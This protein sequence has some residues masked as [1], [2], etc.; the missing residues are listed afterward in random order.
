MPGQYA[1]CGRV[2]PDGPHW[3]PRIFTCSVRRILLWEDI[4]ITAKWVVS[5]YGAVYL[6]FFN[7]TSLIS[8]VALVLLA[9]V[10]ANVAY[11]NAYAA[12]CSFKQQAYEHPNQYGHAARGTRPGPSS[13]WRASVVCVVDPGGA[14]TAAAWSRSTRTGHWHR[15]RWS[16]MSSTGSRSPWLR[17]STARTA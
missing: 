14:S 8:F 4:V 12:Y 10:L 5:L 13:P 7:T 3:L 1:P 17:S 9:A 16:S 15:R 11:V 6:L 2:W